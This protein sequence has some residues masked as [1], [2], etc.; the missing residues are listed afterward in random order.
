VTDDPGVMG[1]LPRSRPG[2]RSAKRAG[3]GGSAKKAA[4]GGK[5]TAGGAKPAAGRAKA[6]KATGRAKAAK[7]TGARAQRSARPKATAS[8]SRPARPADEARR[9]PQPA[10]SGPDPLGD[11]VRVAA[12][13]AGAGVGVAAGI[14]R[15]LPRP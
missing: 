8:R 7:A 11:A 3:S 14:L 1:N 13:L 10:T 9:Q 12:K 6:A 5:Q 4:G 2:Q 15:R